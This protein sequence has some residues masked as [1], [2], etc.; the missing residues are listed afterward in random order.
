MLGMVGKIGLEEPY[1]IKK[2][3]QRHLSVAV[4]NNFFHERYI[5][6]VLL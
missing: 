4:N 2:V 3:C 6:L 1:S 5:S